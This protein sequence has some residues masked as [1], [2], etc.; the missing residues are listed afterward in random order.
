MVVVAVMAE[1]E[2]YEALALVCTCLFISCVAKSVKFL[3]SDFN[4][5]EFYN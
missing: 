1:E 2:N 4:S 5:E 3:F